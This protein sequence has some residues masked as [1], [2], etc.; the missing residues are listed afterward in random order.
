[1]IAI[2]NNIEYKLKI[3]NS[4]LFLDYL[5]LDVLDYTSDYKFSDYLNIFNIINKDKNI[6]KFNNIKNKNNYL[7]LVC[8]SSNFYS[9]VKLYYNEQNLLAY[10]EFDCDYYAFLINIDYINNFMVNKYKN[11]PHFINEL[12]E[13]I[14]NTN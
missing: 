9:K 2:L 12:E 11:I 4:Q 3:A 13:Y 10:F 6:K 5:A 1:M 8:N 7:D 14:S